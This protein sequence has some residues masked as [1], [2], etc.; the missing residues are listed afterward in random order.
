[1]HVFILN[2]LP[3]IDSG[4]FCLLTKYFSGQTLD[5]KKVE[6]LKKTY[7]DKH[8]YGKCSTENPVENE[9]RSFKTLSNGNTLAI[10][11]GQQQPYQ[12]NVLRTW[13]Y[14]FGVNPE[15]WSQH[16]PLTHIILVV[17]EARLGRKEAKE[18]R[19]HFISA[20]S[21]IMRAKKDFQ[22]LTFAPQ[23][24]HLWQTNKLLK[25]WHP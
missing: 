24:L 15:R 16:L 21:Q 9:Q 25:I 7:F 8:G 12:E 20:H 3:L 10:L 5:F 6:N 11:L 22:G 19:T 18:K 17:R 4:V 13:T 1:M 2:V 14:F 23:A